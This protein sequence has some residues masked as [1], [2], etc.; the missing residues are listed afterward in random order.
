MFHDVANDEYVNPRKLGTNSMEQSIL[1][2]LTV[3]HLISKFLSFN[4]T[5]RFITVFKSPHLHSILSQMNS[6]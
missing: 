1:G 4:G 5:R 2:K 3:A 6:V